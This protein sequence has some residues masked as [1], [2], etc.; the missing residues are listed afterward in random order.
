MITWS[1]THVL[2]ESQHDLGL[3]VSSFPN[4]GMSATSFLWQLVQKDNN[5]QEQQ[6][7]EEENYLGDRQL[8]NIV[9]ISK[10]MRINL[11]DSLMM[12]ITKILQIS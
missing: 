8:M 12:T 6:A 9:N 4:I 7:A 11:I 2:F 1:G 3:E 5:N 10:M